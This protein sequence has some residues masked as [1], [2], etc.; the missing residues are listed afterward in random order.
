LSL[1]KEFSIALACEVRSGSVSVKWSVHM[2]GRARLVTTEVVIASL[3][4]YKGMLHISSH[5]LRQRGKVCASELEMVC[6]QFRVDGPRVTGVQLQTRA[7]Q[8]VN[9]I[10]SVQ[11]LSIYEMYIYV[12]A[13]GP[14]RDI[15]R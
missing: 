11:R 10:R 8:R 3:R 12:C 1:K 13:L 9:P 15:R 5:V 2:E 4:N 6:M 14:I 7:E